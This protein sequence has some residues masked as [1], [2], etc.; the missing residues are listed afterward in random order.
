MDITEQ[1]VKDLI[2]PQDTYITIKGKKIKIFPSIE[3]MALFMNKP[4]EPMD[5]KMV[6]KVLFN[7]LKE[8]MSKN[9]FPKVSDELLNKFI[10][11][12]FDELYLELSRVYEIIPAEEVEKIKKKV[13]ETT[14]NSEEK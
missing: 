1:D 14:L 9:E 8:S 10:L 6:Q 12:T 13:Q 7:I 11:K 5:L 3:H 4:G 2:G